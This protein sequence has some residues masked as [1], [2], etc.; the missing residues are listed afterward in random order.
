MVHRS[1]AP[2]PLTRFPRGFRVTTEPITI[3]PSAVTFIPPVI[4]G[5]EDEFVVEISMRGVPSRRTI[6][7]EGDIESVETGGPVT[8]RVRAN[9]RDGGAVR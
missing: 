5:T 2:R 9:N 3:P 7:L 8:E 1:I 6:I 4:E